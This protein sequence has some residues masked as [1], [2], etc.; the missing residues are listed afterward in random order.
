[1]VFLVYFKQILPEAFISSEQ[2][3]NNGIQLVA[4]KKCDLIPEANKLML[5]NELQIIV[6]TFSMM[7]M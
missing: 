7:N 2:Y 6:L 5:F 3:L 1:M 4:D